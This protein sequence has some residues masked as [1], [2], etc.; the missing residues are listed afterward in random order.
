MPRRSLF[1]GQ[2]RPPRQVRA[3]REQEGTF[4][5][6]KR[7]VVRRRRRGKAGVCA[8]NYCKVIFRFCPES[9]RPS[10]PAAPAC[11]SA[12]CRS[13]G[14]TSRC[15]SV[16]AGSTPETLDP[17]ATVY[18]ETKQKFGPLLVQDLR[19]SGSGFDPALTKLCDSDGDNSVTFL[20][21]YPTPH[22]RNS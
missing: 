2:L 14:S 6:Q 10:P 5:R 21:S 12:C 9:A 4:R 17:S 22:Q 13:P 20:K 19:F 18:D 1:G 7:D 11:P 16:R 8:E 15:N 3:Q